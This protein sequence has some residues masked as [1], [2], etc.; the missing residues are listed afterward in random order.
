MD[1]IDAIASDM[2]DVLANL[3]QS[4]METSARVEA[5]RKRYSDWKRVTSA[6]SDDDK[7]KVDPRAGDP[8]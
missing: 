7:P 8:A 4:D 3:A 2:D 6:T 1:T 5:V